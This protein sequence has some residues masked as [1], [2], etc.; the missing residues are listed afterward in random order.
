MRGGVIAYPTEAVWGLGCDP[1]NYSAVS[2]LLT[3]K[4]RTPEKGLILV[5]ASTDQLGSLYRDLPENWKERLAAT[6]P[7]PNTWLIPDR[8]NRIPAW[9]KGK[10]SSV[11]IRVS[12]HPQVI[13][14]CRVFGSMIVS[15]SANSAG[16]PPIRSRI[17]LEQRLG[18]SI[19][20]IVPGALGKKTTPSTIRD[21]ETNSL[22]RP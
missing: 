6:W 22:I 7:G 13:S 5:A 17:K 21:L 15:T 4:L 18:S 10:Y 3:I 19:D 20:Y 16:A 11:A 8:E 14:L 1:W 12:D 2:R 9:I